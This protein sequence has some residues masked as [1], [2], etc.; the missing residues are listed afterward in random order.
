MIDRWF[1][2]GIL[3]LI[4]DITR[5][6][7]RCINPVMNIPSPSILISNKLPIGLNDALQSGKNA[8]PI[9][10]GNSEQINN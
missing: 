8:A 5:M 6:I 7:E 9:I 10:L 1:V 2:S 3:G 4:S